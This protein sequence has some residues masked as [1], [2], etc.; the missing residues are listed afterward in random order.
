MKRVRRWLGWGTLAATLALIG[1]FTF[2]LYTEA[3]LSW[4]LGTALRSSGGNFEYSALRGS[5][6]RGYEIDDAVIELP[7]LTIR[8][9]RLSADV[10]P[11]QLLSG[12]L[13]VDALVLDQAQWIIKP[14]PAS[15]DE[16]KP[17][18]KLDLPFD[19][20]L[21]NLDLRNNSIALAPS[22]EQR[23]G[24][25]AAPEP[26]RS[27]IFSAGAKEISI[28]A[29]KLQVEGLAFSHGAFAVS[30]SGAVDTA[31]QWSG[32]VISEGE[33]KLP[34][35]AQRGELRLSGSSE[36]LDVG[37][38]L[39]EGAVVNLEA[40][41]DRPFDA[42]GIEG[43]LTVQGF[44]PANFELDLP[45][46]RIDLDLH[47]VWT[48]SELSIEGPVAINRQPLQLR[49]A[50]LALRGDTLEIG[51]IALS[52]PAIGALSGAGEWPLAAG[53]DPGKL[54]LST[55]DLWL[56]DWRL[57]LPGG[58]VPRLTAALELSGH[59]ENWAATADGSWRVAE[60]S[61][62]IS[63]HASG[64]PERIEIAPSRI[65]MAQSAVDFSGALQ[66]TEPSQF[67]IEL[68]LDAVDPGL[69]LPEWPGKLDG[70]M[71]INGVLGE[72]VTWEVD[73]VDVSGELRAQAIALSG[74]ITGSDIVPA[75][76]D[77]NLRWGTGELRLSVPTAGELV[78]E[79]DGFDLKALGDYEG[80][81]TGRVSLRPGEDLI[82]SSRASLQIDGLAVADV[83][84]ARV[85]IDKALG[86]NFTVAAD[87]VETVGIKLLTLALTGSGTLDSH[88]IDLLVDND[89]AQLELG[90]AG[91]IVESEWIGNVTSVELTK[92]GAS[93]WTLRDTASL[94][95]SAD[96]ILLSPLCLTAATASL[97]A[98]VKRTA[99]GSLIDLNTVS[100]P[101]AEANPWIA[102]SGVELSGQLDGGGR[103]TLDT[104]GTPGGSLDFR[105]SEASLRG[106]QTY[107]QAV[108]FEGTVRF[109][110]RS[111]ALLARVTLPGYGS[112]DLDATGIASAPADCVAPAV[113]TVIAPVSS[114]SNVIA[115]AP[116]PAPAISPC[117]ASGTVH[118]RID[119]N[120]LSFVDGVTAE[121]QSVR[122]SLRGDITASLSDPSSARGQVESSGLQ[123]ELP[124][125]GLKAT[126]GKVV[127]TLAGDRLIKLDGQFAIAPGELTIDGILSLDASAETKIHVRGNNAGLVDLPA[128]RLAGDTNFVLLRKDGGFA[129][130]GGVL[131]RGG[132]IDLDR[133]APAV[134]ASED[135]V[136]VDAPPSEPGP[137]IHADVSIA[138]IQ[139]VDLRG[140]GLEATLGGG[141]RI[142]QRPGTMTRGE[143]ELTASGV[144]NAYG[145]KLN[146]ERGRLV[147]GG[148]R[149]DDPRFDL[150]A[151]KRVNRQR[152]GVRVRGTAQR[153]L[154]TLYSDPSLDQ[155]EILS[156][157]VLGRPL[158]T[159]SGADGQRLGEYADAL[160][161]A[162]GNLVAGSIGK[163]LG[164]SAGVESLGSA[165][166]SALVVGKY[167]SPRFFV[168]YGT[169]L[170]DAT[171]LVI[172]RYQ[173][174]ENIDLE[175]ISGREQKASVSW[176]TER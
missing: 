19:L 149:I 163:R 151:V 144:Y 46:K 126:S 74:K 96:E 30:A 136:I 105:I 80:R 77:L 173:I 131:L 37:F 107:E 57:P 129:I 31:A 174:T 160:E 70:Q 146:I 64:T 71:R 29:G 24:P 100:F 50:G 169:S 49:A 83:R 159:A 36:K 130:E 142:T 3:G 9:K 125:L 63:L 56:G 26:E 85:R 87:D 84:A 150:L 99:E 8:A 82:A 28:V 41:L 73:G 16:R 103:L 157:L 111:G 79:L 27:F 115:N 101:L 162:G 40:T 51:E 32:E 76:S 43:Q 75:L 140:Y 116:T 133:F 7:A 166:G 110:S 23:A 171:Q 21:R 42:A 91:G 2:V 88:K 155:S 12:V 98:G 55:Q 58:D 54:V 132:R 128:V 156:Y 90:L 176:R 65:Q 60:R 69:L 148:G 6:A 154:A 168:G 114:D 20:R 5:L 104:E 152:V 167:L 137:P 62:P 52:S 122:G 102:E 135:V 86:L 94:R 44:D 118:A 11:Y 35:S 112:I 25:L 92:N 141:V 109:D 53:A 119:L 165:I 68:N 145:Q 138:F 89:L 175:V 108:P 66:L 120:D 67:A 172:L 72:P 18:P 13:G 161:T 170:L 61:G 95:I 121:V 117:G 106:A 45:L 4:L 124:A 113:T 1:L 127:A 34:N 15:E 59:I 147:F 97:C 123:F 39:G 164:L 14:A 158:S 33:W 153:P 143:G 17:L 47:F 139:A 22:P 10:K 134:P 78:A 93:A 38:M 81:A 48:D